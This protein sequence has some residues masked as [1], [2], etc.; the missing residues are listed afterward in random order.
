MEVY[1]G[2]QENT[3]WNVGRLLDEIEEMG[4]RDNTLVIY[5]FGDN[6]ASL[7]GTITGSFNELTMQNGIALTSEQQLSLIEQ[8]GGLDAWGTDAY[9]ALRAAG[10]GRNTPRPGASTLPTGGSATRGLCGRADQGRACA[11][12]P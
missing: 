11:V 5:I 2:F 3:D 9:A 6:G 1:A 8:Y 12:H 4:E 7:E 10:V